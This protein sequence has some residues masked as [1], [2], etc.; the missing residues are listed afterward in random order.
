MSHALSTVTKRDVPTI[1][2]APRIEF[3]L[4]TKGFCFALIAIGVAS[5]ALGLT[6]GVKSD[7]VTS[8]ATF[9]LNA[10]Y[11]F[12]LSMAATGFSAVLHICN[13]QWARPIRRIFESASNY[14]LW[15]FVP[16]VAIY[17]FGA[18]HLF[19]WTHEAIA[20]KGNWLTKNFL[21]PRD[22]IGMLVL[23]VLAR[24][25]VFLSIRRDVGAIRSGLTGLNGEEIARWSDASYDKYVADWGDDDEAEL[26]KTTGKMGRLSPAVVIVY[27]LVMS[28]VAF[29][30]LMSVDPHWYSTLFGV[31]FFM[32]SVYIGVAFVA[33]SIYF[34]RNSHPLYFQKLQPRTLHDLGKLLFGFGIFWAYMFW[35]HYLPIWYGNMPEETLFI[36]ARLR[37]QPWHD[38]AWAVLAM[39]F[40]IPFL[41]GLSR[42]V[43]QIPLL[44]CLTG[45]IAAIG[46][47]LQFYL[48][49]V[50]SLYP[51]V[52]P[53]GFRDIGITLGF[54]G[55]FILSVG[56]F[57]KRAPLIPVGDLYEK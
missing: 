9:H 36:M 15:A 32:S 47:W 31:L 27:A 19:V 21:Y 11:F 17:I 12:G 56:C 49:F 33:I 24:K 7:V 54:L 1:V 52:I 55:V 30:Q 22:I 57:Y 26:K 34:L 20:G 45:V 14:A 40:I 43:K 51:D 28:F 4:L 50:P 37:E 13:G 3:S 42:D 25:V 35:S 23:A 6:S 46:I 2:A 39:C 44:L 41:L 48:L 5:F 29:D 38:F 16:F 18:D 53:L 10:V 8:W